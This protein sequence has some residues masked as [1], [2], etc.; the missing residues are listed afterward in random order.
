MFVCLYYSHPRPGFIR[1]DFDITPMMS[2]YLI[3]FMVTDLVQSNVS[4]PGLPKGLPLINMW[5]RTEVT[6]MTGFGY[7][8]TV[9]VLPFLES[10]FGVPFNLPKIDIVAVPDFG[11]NAMENWGLIT[12]RF[13]EICCILIDR[14]HAHLK[15]NNIQFTINE[16]KHVLLMH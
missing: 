4:R 3:A 8:M 5:T 14:K 10:Y 7:D 16:I 11:F 13:G 15:T 1:E 9:K 6:D 2:T 12:F